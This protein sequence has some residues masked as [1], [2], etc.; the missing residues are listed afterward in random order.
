MHA[1][2]VDPGG[3]SRS[4]PIWPGSLVFPFSRLLPSAPGRAS[5]FPK[6]GF[7]SRYPHVHNHNN[8]G[9]QFR[10]LHPRYPQLRTSPCG[11]GGLCQM[12]QR[13]T[14]DRYWPAGRWRL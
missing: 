4:R 14:W 12:A 10:G 6:P 2:L 13:C 9:A 8:F 5:A 11:L 1:P 3:V 7:P